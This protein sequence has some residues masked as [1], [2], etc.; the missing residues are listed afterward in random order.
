MQEDRSA[1]A[2]AHPGPVRTSAAGPPS[3]SGKVALTVFVD[4]GVR[5]AVKRLAVES[6]SAQ[7]LVLEHALW[8]LFQEAV[9]QGSLMVQEVPP[10][11]RSLAQA[12]SASAS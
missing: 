9:G 11:L 7:Q 10:K 5:R 6:D 1:A 8:L 4:P 3:R 2:L 12:R